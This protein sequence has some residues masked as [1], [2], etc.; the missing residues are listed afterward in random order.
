MTSFM[1]SIYAGKDRFVQD[2]ERKRQETTRR[3]FGDAL[4]N[5]PDALTQLYGVDPATALK[6]KEQTQTMQK[7]SAQL[8][9]QAASA[10]HN[11]APEQK[12]TTYASIHAEMM[13]HPELGAWVSQLPDQYD[14]ATVDPIVQGIIAQTGIYQDQPK[15]GSAPALLQ[16]FDGMATRMGLKPGSPEYQQAARVWANLDPKAK[17]QIVESADGYNVATYGGGAPAVSDPLMSGGSRLPAPMTPPRA[18]AGAGIATDA[19]MGVQPTVQDVQSNPGVTWDNGEFN[20]LSPIEKAK[21]NSYVSRKVPFQIVGGKVVAGQS[22]G[23]Q[24]RPA[25]KDAPKADVPSGY[26]LKAD[27]ASLEPIPGGPADPATKATTVAAKPLPVAA[28]TLIENAQDSLAAAEGINQMLADYSGRI[29][30]GELKVG[31]LQNLISKTRNATNNSDANSKN[32]ASLQA[33]LE[34]MRNQSLTLNKGVQTDG[35]AQ[36]AWNELMA[37]LNDEGVVKQRL[38]EIQALNVRA[39][40]LQREKIARI[41]RNYGGGAEAPA[42]PAQVAAPAAS[43]P[44]GQALS[45][46]ERIARGKYKV[47]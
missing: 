33:T 46:E 19:G 14:P 25:P 7:E 16:S 23:T 10:M 12:A 13:K 8:A 26:R 17:A 31:L 2:Q 40:K 27:G 32:F 34:K 39:A 43:K 37:N 20:S 35:D 41:Q 42:A 1:D 3:L 15:A 9:W 11:A 29:N 5:K 47:D 22:G 38:A 24:L 36:R 28:V 6:A 4:Q 45:I 44:A 21:F 30:R 18:P